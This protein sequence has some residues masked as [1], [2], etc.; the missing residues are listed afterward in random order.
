L[1][2]GSSDPALPKLTKHCRQKSRA[3]TSQDPFPSNKFSSTRVVPLDP[4][5]QRL[6]KYTAEIEVN[7][8]KLRMFMSEKERG[9]CTSSEISA[10]QAVCEYIGK[11]ISKSAAK[12]LAKSYADEGKGC[13][14]FDVKVD[15]GR[16]VCI[17]ATVE[18]GTPGRLINHSLKKGNLKAK[19]IVVEGT[20]RL[21]LVATE[22]IPANRELL[23]DYG[24]RSVRTEYFLQESPIP[25]DVTPSSFCGSFLISQV[26][27]Q[28]A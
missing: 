15:D 19:N 18:D 2:I 28:E 12:Q 27:F 9:V 26:L 10:R 8:P 1:H 3:L 13:F 20:L 24:E 7:Q 14:I 23:Y 11:N 21:F 6:F 22:T 25:M 16:T 17:D 5:T 4:E